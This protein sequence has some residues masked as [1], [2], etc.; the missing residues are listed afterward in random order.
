MSSGYSI[1]SFAAVGLAAVLGFSSPALAATATGSFGV[2]ITIESSCLVVSAT[3]MTFPN[4]GVISAAVDGLS[5]LSVQCT[6]STPYNIGLNV[7]TGSG[8]TVA[9][10][11]MTGPAAATINYSLYSDSTRLTVWGNTVGTDTVSATGN[12]AAQPY[13]VYGRVLFPQTT[14]AAGTYNDTITVTVT[15]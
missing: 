1:R 6:N 8:A 10:R 2:H 3:D 11:K 5:S 9:V 12:G 13:P 7:G 4:T 15:Y 14:P